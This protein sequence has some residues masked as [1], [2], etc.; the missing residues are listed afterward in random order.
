MGNQSW[1]YYEVLEVSPEASQDH[2]YDAYKKAKQTYSIKNPEIFNIFSETEAIDWMNTIE[3]AYSVIGQPNSRR[4]YDHELG[5]N[6]KKNISSTPKIKK[7][8]AAKESNLPEGWAQTVVSQYPINKNMEDLI[9]QQELFDGLFLKKIREY[10]KIDLNDFSRVT[11]IAIRH[12]YAIENNNFASLPA[13]VYVRGYIIQYCRILE[14]DENRV[15][16]S[17]MPLLKK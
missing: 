16:S 8:I 14:L 7:P 13:A 2:I 4:V 11:C 1:N 15:V 3:E 12:L 17:F 9:A 10:K 6:N 5:G